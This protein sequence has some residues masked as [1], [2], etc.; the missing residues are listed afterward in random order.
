MYRETHGFTMEGG[1]N[2]LEEKQTYREEE[3]WTDRQK[4]GLQID[5]EGH[6]TFDGQRER[7][8]LC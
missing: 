4:Y 5:R 7:Q 6:R 1:T 8:S 2:K 3:R